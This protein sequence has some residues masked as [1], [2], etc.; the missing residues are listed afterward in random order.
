MTQV[1]V[2]N[3]DKKEV[4]KIEVPDKMFG[5]KWIPDLVHQALVTQKANSRNVVAHAKDRSEVRGGGKKPWKQKGTGRSRHGS[6]R[7][8][9]WVG[10]G[11]TFGPNKE[12]IFSRKIN[13]VM[14]Q[15]AIFSALSRKFAEDGVVVV[16]SFASGK[17]TREFAGSIKNIF[18]P[19][20]TTTFIFSDKN[21]DNQKISRNISKVAN[22]SPKSL[23][24]YDIMWP[25]KIFIERD[26]VGEIANHYK[27]L[28]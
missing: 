6:I 23:N 26:A 14:N 1:T 16:D 2:Y 25:K 5:T 8:P 13:K 9:L 11:V 21:K 19:K 18:V 17:K 22:L 7:S 10:G 3:L 27:L 4:G 28:K 20:E 24:V 12:R 15:T